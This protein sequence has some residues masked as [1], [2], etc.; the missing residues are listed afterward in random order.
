MDSVLHDAGAW[1]AAD[2]NIL[3]GAEPV[4][5]GRLMNPG[6]RVLTSGPLATVQDL[7]R[8]GFA[9][10]G[11]GTSGAADRGSLR[12]ANQLVG[13]DDATA[14]IE[15]TSGGFTA[16]AY[17]D[18]VVAVTGST[19]PITVDTQRCALNS[20]IAV[21]AGSVLRL[22]SP[23]SGLRSYVAV[24]GGIVV[25]PVLGSRS[26]DL[27]TGIGPPPLRPGT[28]LPVGSPSGRRHPTGFA[29]VEPP[30]VDQ[31]TLRVSPGPRLDWF[32]ETALAALLDNEYT[33]TSECNR[34]GVRLDGPALPRARNRR[35]AAEGIVTGAL[36]VPPSAKPTLCLADHP[37][38][39]SYPTIAVVVA[40]D[41][42]K[43]AQARPGLRLHFLVSEEPG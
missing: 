42:D 3:S 38:I 39:G 20:A 18:L 4:P 22:G 27:L 21:P 34:I 5:R 24:A 31:L 14:A 10:I 11:V 25:E 37:V 6:L 43:A 33:V 7:G 12:L 40:E 36:H 8:R 30:P 26:T 41:V 19:C 15:V 23:A 16:Q 2:T 13:N 32:D 29:S 28:L 1:R 35:L 17:D 9:G